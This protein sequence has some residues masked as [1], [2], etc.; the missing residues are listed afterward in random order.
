MQC[1]R[2]TISAR[3]IRDAERKSS[4]YSTREKALQ[5]YNTDLV[6]KNHSIQNSPAK[7]STIN[8]ST[9]EP[10]LEKDNFYISKKSRTTALSTGVSQR[11]S[12]R[13]LPTKPAKTELNQS[14]NSISDVTIYCPNI[15][16]I[17]NRDKKRAKFIIVPKDEYVRKYPKF[18]I[19]DKSWIKSNDNI[20]FEDQRETHTR[21]QRR[22][23]LGFPK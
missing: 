16:I 8:Q 4:G 21:T 15:G 5:K 22:S 7:Q 17:Q 9:I 12:K 18:V 11:K 13:C 1:S 19:K 10:Q 6:Y 3:K 2:K 20:N 23:P 14:K